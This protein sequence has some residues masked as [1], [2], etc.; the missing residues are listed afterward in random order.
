[1]LSHYCLVS[2]LTVM[3]WQHCTYG[4]NVL[5]FSF[6]IMHA[7]NASVWRYFYLF[8]YVE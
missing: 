8:I 4:K 3:G 2:G 5:R 1:V 6:G 7:Y